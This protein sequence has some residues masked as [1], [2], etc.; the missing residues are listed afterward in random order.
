MLFIY[1]ACILDSVYYNYREKAD[2]YMFFPGFFQILSTGFEIKLI[3]VVFFLAS[4]LF[5]LLDYFN[6]MRKINGKDGS[7]AVV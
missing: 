5:K 7:A 3:P 4:G 6:L 1:V 2:K